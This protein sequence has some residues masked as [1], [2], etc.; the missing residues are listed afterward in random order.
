MP[1]FLPLRRG[2]LVPV[3][4]FEVAFDGSAGDREAAF[5]ATGTS[6]FA[7]VH[8]PLHGHWPHSSGSARL[9]GPGLLHLR[10]GAEGRA[11]GVVDRFSD[12]HNVCPGSGVAAERSS[13]LHA[14]GRLPEPFNDTSKMNG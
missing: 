12:D 2:L 4:D 11:P 9:S 8:S 10:L 3:A 13:D 14:P 5:G 1:L 6:H 7:S